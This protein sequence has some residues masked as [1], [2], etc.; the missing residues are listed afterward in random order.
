LHDK[1]A[2]ASLFDG[3]DSSSAFVSWTDEGNLVVNGDDDRKMFSANEDKHITSDSAGTRVLHYYEDSMDFRG[4]R[5]LRLNSPNRL[6]Q[7][8]VMVALVMDESRVVAFNSAGEGFELMLC[9]ISGHP[10]RLSLANEDVVDLDAVGSSHWPALAKGA[11]G[12]C[13]TKEWRIRT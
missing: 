2:V 1:N 12:G 7:S 6:P 9:N 3:A 8:S 10:S 5:R 11:I 13:K 4:I